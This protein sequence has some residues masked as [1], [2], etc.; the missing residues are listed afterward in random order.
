MGRLYRIVLCLLIGVTC[1][2]NATAASLSPLDRPLEELKEIL[3]R[4]GKCEWKPEFF[5]KPY[6]LN[7]CRGGV[8]SGCWIQVEVGADRRVEDIKILAVLGYPDGPPLWQ[9]TRKVDEDVIAA[10]NIIAALFPGWAESRAWMRDNFERALVKDYHNSIRKD[11]TSIYLA[12][13]QSV[14]SDNRRASVTLT[15]KKDLREFK[16]ARCAN[17]TQGPPVDD[18]EQWSDDIE[19]GF[20]YDAPGPFP[21]N[22]ILF[23]E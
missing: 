13:Y 22:S 15:R 7:H 9:D 16:K 10:S 4:L 1:A 23:L 6:Y 14:T 17:D 18:C 21:R 20:G 3:G 8:E 12:E 11:E 19:G 5:S 2:G